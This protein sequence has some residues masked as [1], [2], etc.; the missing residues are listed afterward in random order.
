MG[1]RYTKAECDI[2]FQID[3]AKH[4]AGAMRCTKVLL[5]PGQRWA[6]TDFA[7]NVG[8]R[9]YCTSTLNKKLNRGDYAG[10][11]AE[12]PKW[13]YGNVGGKATVLPGLV[14]RRADERRAFLT[15]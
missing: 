15:P 3:W 12:F 6:I 13:K 4:E 10:A 7:F 9:R 5:T 1:Q 14:R 8:V 11:A 2:L